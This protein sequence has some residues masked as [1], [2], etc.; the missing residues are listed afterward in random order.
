MNS[1]QRDGEEPNTELDSSSF[2]VMTWSRSAIMSK[3]LNQL[4]SMRGK[5]EVESS[6][7]DSELQQMVYTNYSNFATGTKLI[8]GLKDKA[9]GMKEHLEILQSSLKTS[10][11][12]LTKANGNTEEGAKQVQNLIAITA[13]LAGVQL[14]LA[15]PNRL[16]KSLEHNE[17]DVGVRLWVKGR[18]VLQKH[19]KLPSL[20]VI[21][22]QCK[23]IV[24]TIEARLW[25][26]IDTCSVKQ[27]LSAASSLRL[28][29][30]SPRLSHDL[31]SRISGGVYQ[32]TLSR[33]SSSSPDETQHILVDSARLLTQ[34]AMA[35]DFDPEIILESAIQIFSPLIAQHVDHL[36]ASIKESSMEHMEAAL[37][38]ARLTY[39]VANVISSEIM[40]SD[41]G[42]QFAKVTLL[43]YVCTALVGRIF[44]E[45][46]PPGCCPLSFRQDQLSDALIR[47]SVLKLLST[48]DCLQEGGFNGGHTAAADNDHD[49]ESVESGDRQPVQID[50]KL[51]EQTSK[52]MTTHY[53]KLKRSQ[54]ER[55]LAK[56]VKDI[57][58]KDIPKSEDDA[59]NSDTDTTSSAS[60]ET[61]KWGPISIL[62]YEAITTLTSDITQLCGSASLSEGPVKCA[63]SNLLQTVIELVREMT[64]QTPTVYNELVLEFVLVSEILSQ[65]SYCP[66]GIDS[67][68]ELGLRNLKD[69]YLNDL[70]E[71]VTEND[72]DSDYCSVIKDMVLSGPDTKPSAE[73][74]EIAVAETAT[75]SVRKV[76]PLPSHTSQEMKS[77]FV[78]ELLQLRKLF[79]KNIVTVID[80]FHDDDHCNQ[81]NLELQYIDGCTLGSIA[82]R[83]PHQLSESTA[84]GYIVQVVSGMTYLHANGIVHGDLKGDTVM[85][86]RKT[87]IVKVAGFAKSKKLQEAKKNSNNGSPAATGTPLWMAPEVATGSVCSAASDVWSLG[88][89]TCEVLCNGRP[90]WPNFSTIVQALLTIGNWSEALPPN[91]PSSMSKDGVY[92]LRSCLSP[93]KS[94][95]WMSSA[96]LRHP[97]LHRDS[98]NKKHEHIVNAAHLS[99]SRASL[100]KSAS[101]SCDLKTMFV[102]PPEDINSKNSA[103]ADVCVLMPA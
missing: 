22:E 36:I 28:A 95:R 64:I 23:P 45:V 10:Q 48:E 16:K 92:F 98:I 68:K 77:E 24:D 59:P 21:G 54:V 97:W 102:I 85:V 25:N 91:T 38:V 66:D 71:C 94:S 81:I 32:Q 51:I 9:K 72:I 4:I 19:I 13:T 89:L 99:R 75:A 6:E 55:Q 46:A 2:D 14:L 88:I 74:N 33:L 62:F 73:T 44:Y 39:N 58:A 63:I 29:F 87:G 53:A 57:D 86:C 69:R 103:S 3:S 15:L 93:S 26:Q 100:S 60:T 42:D 8:G 70:S 41:L 78:K 12:D 84:A 50:A 83:S 5:Y 82:R 35:A 90:P 11:E 101:A 40:D 61:I 7:L 17:L 52:G 31:L 20:V 65:H 47:G 43:D 56:V 1:S 80:C 96:L 30:S 18:S 49:D 67:W 37:C 34:C 76:I 27:I 79:H